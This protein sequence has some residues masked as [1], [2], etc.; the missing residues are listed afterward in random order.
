[1]LNGINISALSEYVNEVKTSPQEGQLQ[2]NMSLD[3]QTGTR[4]TAQTTGMNI[5]PHRV[6]RNFGWTVDEPRQ[7]L[8]ANH[9]AT[10]QELLLSGVAGCILVSFIIGASINDIV[11][12]SL[13]VQIS[14][15]LDLSGF[16]NLENSKSV[17]FTNLSYMVTVKSN[18]P[19]EKLNELH[20]MVQ[21]RSPNLMSLKQPIPVSGELVITPEA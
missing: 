5:G 1:M 4:S 8:G 15:E 18:A 3:W 2:Y 7:L 20:K 6:S 13:N 10:P 11:M 12:E 14:G 21:E 9:G 16:F 19:A 17:G